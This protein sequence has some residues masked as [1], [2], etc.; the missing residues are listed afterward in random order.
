MRYGAFVCRAVK[1][2]ILGQIGMIWMRLPLAKSQALPSIRVAF[3]A[4][5]K[6][7]HDAWDF[8]PSTSFVSLRSQYSKIICGSF[9]LMSM[10]VID[11]NSLVPEIDEAI[12][13]LFETSKTRVH[14]F[15]TACSIS[16]EPPADLTIQNVIGIMEW[17]CI[18]E[19]HSS[20][21]GLVFPLCD[22][23]LS[24]NLFHS[25]SVDCYWPRVWILDW[26]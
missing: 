17:L 6:T 8:T 16:F 18:K 2:I 10:N 12:P 1:A 9:F 24:T 7:V 11:E 14:S 4:T 20:S 25:K 5:L 15:A 3:M 23:V 22:S 21:I 26:D 19:F 13:R